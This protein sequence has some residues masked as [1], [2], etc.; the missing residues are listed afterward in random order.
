VPKEIKP[1][2]FRVGM[3]PAGADI[4]VRQGHTVKIQAGAGN[5]SNINDSDYE[6]VGARIVKSAEEVW[7][8]DMV[9]KVKE[10]LAPEYPLIN[11]QVLFTYFHFGADRDL[12]E[13]MLAKKAVCIAYET[14]QM[15]DGSLPLLIPMSEVAGR[16]AV[17][18]GAKYLERPFQGR[19]KLLAGVP[20]V[21]PGRVL[22]IGGGIVGANAARVAAGLG[23]HVTILD[24]NMTR[25]RYLSDIFPSNVETIFSTPYSVLQCIEQADV[26]IGAVYTVGE[27]APKLIKRDNLSRFKDRAVFVDV[28][29]DQGGI[30]ETSRATTH[31][32][33]TY[34]IDG[35][36]HYCVGNIPG[37]VP[38]T[39]TYALTN[40][41]LKYASL[42][43]KHGWKN[44]CRE[45]PELK[46]GLN[47]IGDALTHPGVSRSFPDLPYKEA[48]SLLQ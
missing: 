7:D 25:L 18:E 27:T 5:G 21:S 30:S 48:D 12:T 8:S 10:P 40:V 13:A 11:D 37:A 45:I 23:A 28:S 4:L 42:L 20:G 1:D 17:Q 41:T 3:T 29:I 26:V 16:M 46:L 34:A 33:P 24:T 47:K 36:N 6:F 14:V 32:K 2:E 19:G 39:S 38:A 44:A 15:K 9:V 43:A 31:S 35:V 22:V